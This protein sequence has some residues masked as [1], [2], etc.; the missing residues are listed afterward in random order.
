MADSNITKR[1]LAL[2]LKKLMSERPFSKVSIGDICDQC[3]MNRKSFYYHFKDKYDLVN[4]IFEHEFVLQSKHKSYSSSSEAFLDLCNYLKD[5]REFYT[6]AFKIEGQNS[7]SEY[8]TQYCIKCFAKELNVKNEINV[9]KMYHV[10][11][12]VVILKNVVELWIS[13]KEDLPA[14]EFCAAFDICLRSMSAIING[15]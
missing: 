15:K 7:F 12:S 4:W 1:S 10:K 5:N 11:M 2:S 3:G 6:Q 9:I 14:N 13:D 8:F